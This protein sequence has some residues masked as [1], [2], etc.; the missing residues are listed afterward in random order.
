MFDKGSRR[1]YRRPTGAEPDYVS[2]PGLPLIGPIFPRRYMKKTPIRS[3]STRTI[4]DRYFSTAH[5]SKQLKVRAV[6]GWTATFI[7][8]I[9]AKAIHLS[10]IAVL[11]RLLTP[12]DFGLVAMIAVVMGF[13]QLCKDLGLSTATIQQETITH[14][15]VSTLFWIN[16]GLGALLMVVTLM[17][18]PVL[19]WFYDQEQLLGLTMGFSVGLFI[20]GLGVQHTAL[21][22]RQMRL[23]VLA[24]LDVMG[25][26]V[27]TAVGIIAALKGFAV[28]SL[29]FME[30]AQIVFRTIAVWY[31]CSWRPGRPRR[32]VGVGRML[33]FGGNLTGFNLI[34]YLATR[35]DTLLIG[36][37]S[38]PILLGYYSRAFGLLLAPLRQMNHPAT[39]VAIP[40]LSRIVEQGDRYRRV[41]FR[42]LN[43][44][45]L[46]TVPMITF[47]IATSD[48]VV[49]VVLGPQW[50]K[51]GELF[52]I[53]GFAGLII[54]ILNTFGWLFITQ[55][56]TGE[57]LHLGLIDAVVKI[58][59]VVIGLFWGVIGV[60]VAVAI[61]YYLMLPV[62]LWMVCRRGPVRA[63]DYLPSFFLAAALSAAVL[64]AVKAFR[65]TGWLAEPAL[66]IAGSLAVTVMIAAAMGLL[67][68]GGRAT[69]RDTIHSLSTL[70]K[71]ESI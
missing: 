19:A 30:L 29:V 3:R 33:G 36:W 58:L 25:I 50:E 54:P 40:T 70:F 39:N 65:S 4:P 34:N 12:A 52:W 35:L 8:Q 14:E 28:W 47:L 46:V 64:G 41:Y 7:G 68:P 10:A 1:H 11:A 23:G 44:I 2:P 37:Y 27:G 22:Q 49:R 67:L 51:A 31:I 16:I 56:R 43:Q 53:L 24:G 20:S 13:V 55:N 6:R 63:N 57:L 15:Q 32:G 48:W 61:R 69:I 45:V 71:R 62:S 60:A 66:G 38:G 26:F 17:L 59:S 42:I 9:L 21:L 5:L 18:A